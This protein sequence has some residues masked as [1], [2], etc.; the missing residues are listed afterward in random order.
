[1]S[2]LNLQRG[3]IITGVFLVGTIFGQWLNKPDSPAQVETRY[4]TVVNKLDT[5]AMVC[6]KP[7][8]RGEVVITADDII[9]AARGKSLEFIAEVK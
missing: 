3:V 2:K 4:D 8:P 1:M 9:D 6:A 5:L 7:M